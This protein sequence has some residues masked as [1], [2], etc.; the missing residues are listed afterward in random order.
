MSIRKRTSKKA[1]N[2]YVYEVYFNYKTNGITNRYTK[3]GF[4]TKK[5]AQEHEAL[6]LAE[7]KESGSIKKEIKKSLENV[8]HEFLEVGSAQYQSSTIY[9]TK[10]NYHYF[11]KE[12]GQLPIAT[13]D[14]SILQKY[15]NSRSKY[16]IETNK[17]IKKTIS[18]I[19]NFAIKVGYIKS[20]PLNLVTVTGVENH[21]DHEK[22]LLYDD[23][24]TIINALD[25]VDF[26]R[27]AYSI[28]IQIGYYTGLRISEVLALNKSD[29]DLDNNL[30]FINK[31][32]LYKDLKKENYTTSNQ[33]K[34]KT[35]KAIIPLANPLK[36]SLIEWFKKNPYEKVICDIDGYYINPN[37]LSL[38]I[39]KLA[40]NLGISFHF[41][42]LRHTF[43][44]NLVNS[45]VDLKTAQELMR[46]SNINTTMSIY[47]HV[48]DQHKI[49]VIN[50]VFDIK[51][52]EKVSKTNNNIKTLN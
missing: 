37:V 19:L 11:E 5:E 33:M 9:S 28:A 21:L 12:L 41:H 35:S 24:K 39:K 14:Y 27:K 29:F 25:K 15:F 16:G 50:N 7:V 22:V 38:D 47:T 1:K 6:M 23:F 52:V 49:N 34:S 51:S 3:S 36:H 45:N 18:R 2:G 13:I 44:T 48:N 30:I 46:H 40:K 20:N 4:K 31:K 43:A 26:K 42:M 10:K 32:L 8:Y 17:N